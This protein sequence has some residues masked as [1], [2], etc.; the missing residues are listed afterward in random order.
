MI[1]LKTGRS[2]EG[3]S[4]PGAKPGTIE[5]RKADGVVVVL[6]EADIVRI[7]KKE[8]PSREL[9]RRLKA[10]PPGEIEPLLELMAWSREKSLHKETRGIARRILEI[11]PHHEVAR[12]ELGYVVYENKWM[13][14]SELRKK[15]GL[16][17]FRDEWMETSE[18]DRRLL[19]EA[20]KEVE[21][22]FGLVASENRYIQAYAIQKIL[23]RREPALREAFRSRLRDA[24]EAVRMVAMG[25]L[26]NLAVTGDGD[27]EGRKIAAEIQQVFLE[28][29]SE[30]VLQV[31]RVT[32]RKFHPRE[33]Y[34]LAREAA[35]AATS[36]EHRRRAEEIVKLLRP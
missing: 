35:A 33:S 2:I 36:E 14:E 27:A 17:R 23:A 19:E 18:R 25:G 4:A 26:A 28:D 9:E 5:V 10:L 6:N 8:N 24:R 13:L 20:L 29:S 12:K 21:D 30:G 15:K 22:L 32:L 3:A 1:H 34:R 16:V 7:E 11:D 31:A